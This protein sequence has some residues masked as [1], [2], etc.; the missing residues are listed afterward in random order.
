MNLEK[1]WA[2]RKSVVEK[3]DAKICKKEIAHQ[4]GVSVFTIRKYYND[5]KKKKFFGRGHPDNLVGGDRKT[6]YRK[7]DID[8]VKKLLASGM[9]RVKAAREVKLSQHHIKKIMVEINRHEK[10]TEHELG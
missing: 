1:Y 2:M 4:V 5:A 9:S 3:I 7:S 8:A 6:V 10:K